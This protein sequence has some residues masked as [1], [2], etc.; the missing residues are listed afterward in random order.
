MVASQDGHFTVFVWCGTD[1]KVHAH[2]V[3]A[4]P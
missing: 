4:P 3:E 1:E 2:R